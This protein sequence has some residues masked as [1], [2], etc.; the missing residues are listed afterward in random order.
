MKTKLLTLFA[1]FSLGVASAQTGKYWSDNK[2]SKAN[3]VANNAAARENFPK[4]FKLFNLN[5]ESL[6]QELGSLTSKRSVMVT[7]PNAEGVLEQFELYEASNFDAELQAQF[8]EIR[9]FSGKGITDKYATLKMSISPQGIQT[10]VSRVG[11]PT[12]FMEPYSQDRKVYAVYRS[13]REKGRMSINCTTDDKKMFTD[14]SNQIKSTQ[15]SSAGQLKTMRLAQSCTGEYSV[16][17]ANAIAVGTTPT[18]AIS[19]AAINASLTRCNGVYEKDLGLHL[20]LVASSTNVIYTNAA[21]DPYGDTDANYNSELQAALDAGG[22]VGNANYDIGHLFSAIGNNGNAGCIGCVCDA[23]KG[24]G[25]TTST[26][27][28]GDN[29]DIDFIVHEVGHQLGANHTFSMSNEGTG[30]NMEPGSGVSIMGYAGI[31]SYDVT[32]H[33]IDKFHA[34]S[35]N[36][37]QVNL[38]SKSC[39]I[40]TVITANNATPVVNAGLD[41]TIPRSTPFMLTGSATDANAGDALTYQWEQ[42]D[43]ASA[44]QTNAN[45]AASITKL[46]GPNWRSYDATT[47][48]IRVFPNITTVLAGQATTAGS[49]IN[50]EALSSVAR[51][52]NFRL[53]VR[54]NAPYTVSPAK[55]GQTNFDDVI[56]T[57]DA[58]RGPLTVTSQ[59]VDNQSWLQ[60]SSQTITWAVNGTDTSAGGANVDI[61]LSTDGGL[62][63]P[64]VLLAGTPNDG[65]QSITVPNITAQR[66]RVMVKA[67]GSI[68]FNVNARDIAVG[69]TVSSTCNNYNVNPNAPIPDNSGTYL[70]HGVNVPTTDAITDVNLAV[71]LTHTWISDVTVAVLSPLGTQVN[72]FNRSCNSNDNINATFDDQGSAIVCAATITGNVIPA[73]PL[74]ALNGQNPNGVWT[75]GVVDQAADDTGTIVSY[76]LTVCSK[77]FTLANDDFEFE[78]FELYPNPSNGNFTVKFVSNTGNDVKVNVH[79]IRGRQIFDK[80]YANNGTFN[81]TISL[82]NAQA[83]VY[84]LS[85]VD[86]GK[87]TVKRIVIE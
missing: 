5:F 4:E 78:A 54:D 29:F 70:T 42:M 86:G 43:N 19:L 57:V 56:V 67:S 6:R 15:R 63:Y 30:V 38:A 34:A 3:L 87:K 60:N 75:F 13:N 27:P 41:Y 71:N 81:Q 11:S 44:A 77:Q 47:T 2:E 49:E 35:I 53:T 51:P 31:T 61:L 85:V 66:C 21:T 84:L 55:V 68:F 7:L 80:S 48:P 40:T 32:P 33:S 39:P 65:S 58:T 8:P 24:S 46:T 26:A 83:G 64:T 20:N 17:H 10:M 45:S 18:V 59:N 9:A 22:G 36:Q 62:T 69:Y 14:L 74:S 50:V 72:V 76:T 1:F 12:E 82:D 23:G 16:Y 73:Q 52:L 25:F 79:D 28:V 37:I